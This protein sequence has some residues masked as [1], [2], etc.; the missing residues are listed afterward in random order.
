[1]RDS[2]NFIKSQTLTPERTEDG[3]GENVN[4][5]LLLQE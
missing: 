3:L 2:L 1:M 5:G 4:H